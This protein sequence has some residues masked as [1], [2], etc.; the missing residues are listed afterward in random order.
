VEWTV[1]E[2]NKDC[3]HFYLIQTAGLIEDLWGI[4]STWSNEECREQSTSPTPGLR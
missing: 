2:K 1:N 3:F 4:N